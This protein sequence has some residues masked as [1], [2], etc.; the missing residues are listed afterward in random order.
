MA[1]RGHSSRVMGVRQREV[2]AWGIYRKNPGVSSVF[3]FQMCRVLA[4]SINT[5]ELVLFSP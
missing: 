5:I 1:V 2:F 4:G 3:R